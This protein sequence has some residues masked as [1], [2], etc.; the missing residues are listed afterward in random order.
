MSVYAG[1]A[2][3]YDG[4]S[5]MTG[6]SAPYPP[7]EERKYPERFT[8]DIVRDSLNEVEFKLEQAAVKGDCEWVHSLIEQGADKNAE[9]DKDGKT[10]LMIASEL[11]WIDLVKQLVEVEDVDMEPLSK[12]GLRAIDYAGK[13]QFRWPNEIEI[14]DY[15]KSKGSQYT[16]W[17][18]ACA[19][20]IRRL[21]VYLQNGQDI[22]EMNPVLYNWSAMDACIASGCGKAAAFLCA[23]GALLQIRNCHIAVIPEMKWSIGRGDSFMYKEL[24][25]EAG[26]VQKW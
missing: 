18:A 7:M 17:G 24:Q 20:D 11:G 13:E 22:D 4:I 10:A 9:L 21:D 25:L 12:A 15:L 14:A 3:M 6:R 23:R 1:F 16:W 26:E 19:G 2:G 8:N 5:T